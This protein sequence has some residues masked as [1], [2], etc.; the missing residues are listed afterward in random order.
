MRGATCLLIGVLVV[1]A[2][3]GGTAATSA[4]PSAT[5]P[6]TEVMASGEFVEVDGVA[7]GSAK[8]VVMGELYEVVLESFEIDSI[9]HTNVILVGNE[10][11]TMSDDI[12]Q[13]MILDLG[14][15]Q[16]ATGMQTYVIPAEMSGSVMDD[17][18]SV[19]I[20]DT[21]MAHAIAAAPLE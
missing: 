7:S 15:L 18:H 11:I 21:E 8:L 17:Y 10:S 14:P 12:D 9:A 3:G 1:A 13:T 5:A 4:P 20:W 6:A 2:C 16:A 19:V